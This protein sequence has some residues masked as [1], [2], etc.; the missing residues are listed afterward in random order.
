M[1][2]ILKSLYRSIGIQGEIQINEIRAFLNGLGKEGEGLD[3]Q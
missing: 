3:L 2:G 1:F